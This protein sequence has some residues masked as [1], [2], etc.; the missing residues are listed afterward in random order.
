MFASLPWDR[1]A[2]MSGT[3]WSTLGLDRKP[4]FRTLFSSVSLIC[5]KNVSRVNKIKKIL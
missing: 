2:D 3:D 1:A 4:Y 5:V